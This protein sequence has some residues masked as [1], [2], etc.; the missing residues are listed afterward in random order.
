MLDA[1]QLLIPAVPLGAW[2]I[3]RGARRRA[4][5][6]TVVL[7]LVVL[8]HLTAVVA[9]AF[10]PFPIQ[11]ELIQENRQFQLAH[12]N[13]VPLS[14]LIHALVTGTTPSVI[15]QS[16]GN[17]VMLMPVGVYLPLLVRPARRATT[18]VLVGLALSLAIEFGQL[19]ISTVLGYTYKIADI[20]DVILNT[21]GVAI[22]YG[23]YWLISHGHRSLA[24]RRVSAHES[25]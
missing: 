11:A 2:I 18:M 20:D 6:G 14:S 10:F 16:V 5:A 3:V 24:M 21:A 22:G 25:H 13:L 1:S 4:G 12:N 8:A 19:V 23:S 7:Q 17:L 15:D 9:V